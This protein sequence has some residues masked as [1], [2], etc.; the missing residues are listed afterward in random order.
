MQEIT[1]KDLD[2][3]H[4]GPEMCL[5]INSRYLLE[6]AFAKLD[7]RDFTWEKGESLRSIHIMAMIEHYPVLF[8]PVQGK[9]LHSKKLVANIGEAI[10][11]LQEKGFTVLKVVEELIQYTLYTRK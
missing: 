1:L 10:F 4:I 9:L 6:E 2:T 5:L 11:D 8:L 3:V 7:A